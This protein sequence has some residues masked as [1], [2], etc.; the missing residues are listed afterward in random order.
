MNGPTQGRTGHFRVGDWPRGTRNVQLRFEF[1]G[2]NTVG[3]QH[4]RVDADYRD[5]MAA[6]GARSFRVIHRWTEGGKARSHTE[7]ITRLPS[8][9]AI[10]AR[11][12]PE[13]VSVSYEMPASR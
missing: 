6:K 7:N 10:Q 3:V 12:D 13:M 8:T 2:N 1:T 4:F 9:Y 5:R 11:S